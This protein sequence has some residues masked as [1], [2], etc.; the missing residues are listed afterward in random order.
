[1][2]GSQVSHQIQLAR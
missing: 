1:M 2:C